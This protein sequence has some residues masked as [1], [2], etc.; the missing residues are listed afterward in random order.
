MAKKKKDEP[1]PE[2]EPEGKKEKKK[3]EKKKKEPPAEVE[4]VAVEETDGIGALIKEFL[5]SK[6]WT[7][8][9]IHVRVRR[10][11]GRLPERDP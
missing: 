9:V 3:K 8:L 1:E 4:A 10:L 6:T 11:D 7:T 5:N 2:P